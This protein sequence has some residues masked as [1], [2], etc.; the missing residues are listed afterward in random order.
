VITARPAK[1]ARPVAPSGA[2]KARLGRRPLQRL[3]SSVLGSAF[4]DD[5]GFAVVGG[6]SPFVETA[7]QG[8]ADGG[9][10]FRVNQAYGAW[11]G[12]VGVTP[13]KD[14][15][16]SFG[17]ITL[18]V[19][20]GRENPAG[21]AKIFDGR[22]KF[23]MEIGETDFTGKSGGGFFLEDPE[24]ETEERPVAGVA[25]KFDPGFFFGERAAADELGYGGVGPHGTAGGEIFEAMVAETKTRSFDDG[26]FRSDRH[27]LDHEESL[28]QGGANVGMQGRK[29]RWKAK[30][31]RGRIDANPPATGMRATGERRRVSMPGQIEKRGV[32]WRQRIRRTDCMGR[33]RW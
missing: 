12:E 17:G 20:A 31:R 32:R 18:A 23:A 28:A 19:H 29:E 27:R 21:F 8:D 3:F 22:D 9:D 6:A 5:G 7:F 24:A 4:E 2:H 10:V 26:K 15:G 1:S 33:G 30:W 25:E 14:G 16:D 13:G 11:I